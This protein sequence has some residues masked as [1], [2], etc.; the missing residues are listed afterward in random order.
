MMSL[1]R[2]NYEVAQLLLQHPCINVNCF[3]KEGHSALLWACFR[4]YGDIVQAIVLH[5]GFRKRA[6]EGRSL[7]H[8]A[9]VHPD[10]RDF[11]LASG[12]SAEE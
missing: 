6:G 4:G 1:R 8:E 11:L 9:A 5:P 12:F 3:D 2:G 7:L 10:I